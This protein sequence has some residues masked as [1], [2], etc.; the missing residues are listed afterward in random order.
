MQAIF[1]SY[2]NPNSVPTFSGHEFNICI[3]SRENVCDNIPVDIMEEVL[4]ERLSFPHRQPDCL[5]KS[6]AW[7]NRDYKLKRFL[8]GENRNRYG[9]VQSRRKCN[10]FTLEFCDQ[11]EEM[12]Q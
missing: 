9:V 6:N 3:R 5:Q 2:D 4:L 10:L 12:L 8:D 1:L 11:C 7:W